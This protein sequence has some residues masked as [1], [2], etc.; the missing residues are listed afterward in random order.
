MLTKTDFAKYP[1]TTESSEYIR[2]LKIDV[3]EL[4]SG[5]YERV[6]ER[7]EQRIRESEKDAM[8][9]P[10]WQDTDVEILSFPTAVM[11]VSQIGNDR[12][13]RRY[14]L[15]ES[16]RAY[17]LLRSETHEK[18]QEIA[19]NTFGWKMVPQQDEEG[20]SNYYVH[21]VDYLRNAKSI[22]DQK[23]KLV[24]RVLENGIVT[25]TRDEAARLLEEEVQ[26]KVFSRI[27]PPSSSLPEPLS[28]R[29][30]KIKDEI[31]AGIVYSLESMPRT[32]VADAMPPCIKALNE[33]LS[34]KKHISH[35]GRFTLT[36]F[37][38]NIGV[39]REDLVKMF[40]EASDFSERLTRYQV[41]HIGGSKGVKTRYLPPRCDTLKTHGIC[42]NPDEICK[43]IRHP[44]GYYRK[45]VFRRRNRT[46]EY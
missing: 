45:R 25:L 1:F 26:Q 5:G 38:L 6:L 14:A 41:E 32:V 36:S 19:R 44:L 24:N 18:L 30:R 4:A 43:S 29:V 46:S 17:E 37:L 33:S 12:V 39:S 7:A 9:S 27:R 10:E 22:R 20:N 8:I 13:S 31:G 21:F 35:M 34:S 28:D 11:F 3:A 2:S 42:V 23:W 15:A 16:K 40:K